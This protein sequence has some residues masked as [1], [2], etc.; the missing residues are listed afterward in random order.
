MRS[1]GASTR[2]RTLTSARRGGR[3][4]SPGRRG[5]SEV[6]PPR[7][8]SPILTLRGGVGIPP[9]YRLAAVTGLYHEGNPPLQDAFDSRR[10]A[11]RLDAVTV[12]DHIDE[13]DQGL[14]REPRHVLPGHRR[15]ARPPDL[16]LHPPLPAGRALALRARPHQDTPVPDS[17]R[18]DWAADV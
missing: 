16:H 13:G 3:S 12:R 14:R 4:G 2:P 9:R 11:D 5:R 6:H 15:R 18:A 1:V 8:F 7:S 17:K 10:L